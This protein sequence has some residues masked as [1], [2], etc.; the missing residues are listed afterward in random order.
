[1]TLTERFEKFFSRGP[2]C[3]EWH[4]YVSK[5]GYGFFH[6]FGRPRP[7][8]RVAYEIYVGEIPGGLDLDHLCRNRSCVN[9]AHLQPVTRQINILR[10]IVPFIGGNN[11]RIKTHCP[12]GPS[13]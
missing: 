13:I 8:H 12:K 10:G 6:A 5:R 7:A 3:W 11:N 1:M 2:G 4:G 9:P